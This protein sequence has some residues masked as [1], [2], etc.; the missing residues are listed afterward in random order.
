L[1]QTIN[2]NGVSIGNGIAQ[3]SSTPPVNLQQYITA[4]A[5]LSGAP[6]FRTDGS[7]D[8]PNDHH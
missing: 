3:P 5:L 4:A 1:A 2:S 7:G 8:G 6:N